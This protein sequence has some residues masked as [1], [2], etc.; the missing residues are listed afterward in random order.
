[1]FKAHIGG[2]RRVCHVIIVQ[3]K[4]C[5]NLEVRVSGNWTL[6]KADISQKCAQQFWSQRCL[7]WLILGSLHRQ[8]CN[9]TH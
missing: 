3:V 9:K 7:P 2:V 8:E 6:S 5:S 4:Y 1:M